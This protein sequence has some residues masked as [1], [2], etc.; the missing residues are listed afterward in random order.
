MTKVGTVHRRRSRQKAGVILRVVTCLDF[1]DVAPVLHNVPK[2]AA[3]GDRPALVWPCRCA[4]RLA[5]QGALWQTAIAD[6]LEGTKSIESIIE[7]RPLLGPDGLAWSK[8][9]RHGLVTLV[10]I[11]CLS[12][13]TRHR[14]SGHVSMPHVEIWVLRVRL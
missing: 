14:T 1:R 2:R 6:D 5:E 7:F 12:A 4:C 8:F 9:V 11:M 10:L 13:S 3:L